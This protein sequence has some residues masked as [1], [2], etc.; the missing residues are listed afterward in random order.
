MKIFNSKNKSMSEIYI[1]LGVGLLAGYLSGMVGIGGG[2][3]IVPVLV[4]VLNYTQ[5]LAQGT[6][7]FMFMFPIGILGVLQYYKSGNVD[8][9]TAMIIALPFVLGSFLGSKTALTIDQ[10]L[11]KKIFGAI[12]VILGFKMIFFK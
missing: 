5:Q 7:L 9:K 8:W 4:Y 3:V 11:L 10:S 6:T 12:I 1:L 2:I